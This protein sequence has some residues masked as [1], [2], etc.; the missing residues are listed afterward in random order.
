M[1]LK[2]AFNGAGADPIGKACDAGF[3]AT[4]TIRLSDFG[5]KTNMPLIGDTV[6]QRIS[7]AV[8]H[9]LQHHRLARAGCL[10]ILRPGGAIRSARVCRTVSGRLSRH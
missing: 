4:A 8:H 1:T 10:Q 3:D 2:T 6:D 9:G 5:V 7:A